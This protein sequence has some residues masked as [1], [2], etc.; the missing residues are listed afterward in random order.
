MPEISELQR[1]QL[2]ILKVFTE[3]CEKHK[4]RY[5]MAEGSMLGTYRHK[6]F[7]PWDDDIDVSMPRRDYEKFQEIAKETLP[8]PYKLTNYKDEGH[9]W[10]TAIL[11][12]TSR[13]V[14]LSNATEKIVRH[15]WIDVAPLDGMPNGRIRQRLHYAHY[16]LYRAIFQASHFSKI[17]NVQRQ[18]PLYERICIKM[19]QLVNVE[20]LL[21]STKWGGICIP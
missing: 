13:N 21:V 2:G 9:Y 12:D 3:I 16:Y 7:I 8:E 5:F 10:M 6:G 1:C 20:K 4:L 14:V 19:C 17:V 18:R 15:P 11:W